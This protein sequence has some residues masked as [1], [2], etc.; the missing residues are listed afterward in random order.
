MV[1]P[2]VRVVLREVEALR[3]GRSSGGF[4]S[5]R[6]RTEREQTAPPDA[7]VRAQETPPRRRG[8]PG[9]P[10]LVPCLIPLF[11]H[12]PTSFV[13]PLLPASFFISNFTCSLSTFCFTVFF[14]F[15]FFTPLSPFLPLIFPSSFIPFFPFFFF[16]PPVLS[17][18]SL[19]P[20][21]VP[22]FPASFLTLFF[23]SSFFFPHFPSFLCPL[24]FPFFSLGPFIITFPFPFFPILSLSLIPLKS[25]N[26]AGTPSSPPSPTNTGLKPG[27][28][29]FWG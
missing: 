28:A 3:G 2:G 8:N 24:H 6:F 16:W 25:S 22:S 23:P 4:V 18:S 21:F 13:A 7:P 19:F 20:C 29:T 9:P 15:S 12:F 5:S 11:T 1:A 27:A 17:L 14:H 26:P 10:F